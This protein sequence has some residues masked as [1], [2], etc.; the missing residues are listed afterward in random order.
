MLHTYQS[1]HGIWMTKKHASG[2]HAPSPISAGFTLMEL[3]MGIAVLAILTTLAVPA[4]NQFVQSN[5][6][7]GQTNEMVAALQYARSE[8]L[9]RGSWAELCASADQTTCGG[10]MGDGWIVQVAPTSLEASLS[11]T[12]PL[13]VWSGPGDRIAISA[14]Q[15][16]AR[17]NSSGCFDHDKDGECSAHFD[18]AA[19]DDEIPL[20]VVE[21][22]P[23]LDAIQPRQIRIAETGRVTSCR[24][25]PGDAT[26]CETN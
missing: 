10:S 5:R 9:K 6:L 7:A 16:S 22:E 8:A 18:A 11:E 3:L 14:V 1:I 26:K 25:D 2:I 17:F 12:N 23:D 20:F 4:F 13:R 21:E 24:Q 19:G 15:N